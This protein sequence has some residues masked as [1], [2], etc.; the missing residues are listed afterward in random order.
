MLFTAVSNGQTCSPNSN[1]DENYKWATHSKWYYG[2]SNLLDFGASGTGAGTRVD[3]TGPVGWYQ[4]YESVASA[5]DNSG[6]LV[7]ATNGVELW[8]GTG[9]AIAVPGGRLLTGA[10][11]PTGDAGSAVHGVMIV[12]HPLDV[13]NYYIFTGDDAISGQTSAT[14]AVAATYGFNYYI[15]NAVSNSIT[16]GPIRLGNF[17]STEQIAAT[18]HANKVDVWI[19]T[20][21]SLALGASK[22]AS[23]NT[24]NAYLLKCS[25]LVTAPVPS[26]LGFEVTVGADWQGYPDRSNERASLKFSWDGTKAAATHHRGNGDVSA[27]TDCIGTMDFDNATGLFSAWNGINVNDVPHS[28]PYCCE[29]SPS[30]NRLFVSFQSDPWSVPTSDGRVEYFPVAGGAPTLVGSLNSTTDVG[31]LKLGGDGAIYGANFQLSPWARRDALIKISNP[32]G[33]ATWAET[34]VAS[35]AAAVS[36]GLPS[37]FIPPRDWLKI[38]V[39][40]AL[41]ECDLPYNFSTNWVCRATDAEN[42]LLY[43]PA[44]AVLSGPAGGS[45]NAITGVFDATAPGTYEITFTICT[46]ADTLEFVVGTCGCTAEVKPGPLEFCAGESVMLDSLLVSSSGPGTW[47]IDS[48][49]ASIPGTNLATIDHGLTD[50]MFVTTISTRPGTYKLM[51]TVTGGGCE[52]S[53]YI[54]VNPIPV[55][56][57]GSIGPFCKSDAAVVM[58]GSPQNGADTTGTWLIDGAASVSAS[59][60]PS[61]LAVGNHTVRYTATVDNC[62]DFIDSVFVINALPVAIVNHDTICT[63]V[64]MGTFTATADSAIASYLWSNNASG[65]I[66]TATG[67][68]AGNYTVQITDSHGC[69]DDTTG[70]LIVN[71]LPAIT[72]NDSTVCAGTSAKFTAVSDS[73][74]TGP[75]SGY[76][77]S[78]KG[79]GT[80]STTDGTIAGDYIV[81]VTDLHGCIGTATGVLTVNPLKDATITT[82]T[83]NDT[84]V[85]CALD[86]VD[87]TVSVAEGGGTWDNVNV[88][89]VGTVATIDLSSIAPATDLRLIYTLASPCGDADTIWI[90]TTSK[91]VASVAAMGPYC[92]SDN[93]NYLLTKSVTANDGGTWWVN[94]VQNLTDSINPSVLTD[95]SYAI[96]YRIGGLCG[97]TGTTTIVVDA[98][99]V[100]TIT[101]DASLCITANP[102][103]LTVDST[104]GTWT[105]ILPISGG[106]TSA[107]LTFNP[108]T[109]A[110]GDFEIAH[111]VTNGKCSHKD[112]VYITVIDTPKFVID[113]I[114][115]F[116]AGDAVKA[117]SISP[118][119]STGGTWS[120]TA[121]SGLV[122]STFDP[123][124]ASTSVTNTIRYTVGTCEVFQEIDVTVEEQSIAELPPNTGFC[125]ADPVYQ[126]VPVQSS[127]AGAATAYTATCGACFNA[128][129]QMFDPSLATIGSNTI[130]YTV[131]G[132]CDSTATMI[133]TVTQAAVITPTSPND[134]CVGDVTMP[135]TFSAAVGTATGTG[136][137]TLDAP[138]LGSIDPTTGVWSGASVTTGGTVSATYTFTT[139]DPPAPNGCVSFETTTMEVIDNPVIDFSRANEDSCV[140]YA[141]VFTDNTSYPQ[142]TLLGSTWDF[143]NGATGTN[144]GSDGTNYTVAGDYTVTLSN[145]YA[146][147]CKATASMIVRVFPLPNADF[148]WSPNPASILDPRIQFVSTGDLTD[149]YLWGFTSQ[150]TPE[151][152]T[153]MSP[154]SVFEV[155]GDDTIPVTLLVTNNYVTNL[156]NVQGCTD[157]ITKNVIIQDIFQLYVPNAFTPGAKADG[158]NDTF[159]PVGRNWALDNFEFVVL[160]RW[161]N[162]IFKTTTIG[163][164]WDGTVNG[165]ASSGKLAQND[166]YVWKITVK[167]I[168]TGKV[169][170]K[171]GAVTLVR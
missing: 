153:S 34:G 82:S 139:D 35:G 57:I 120:V 167:N 52:D 39:P 115:P 49:P 102:I 86:P 146:N 145:A 166:V 50:T 76:V 20:H 24:Y 41:T 55:P 83:G 81:T 63:G 51:Y 90:T 158:L 64:G 61:L 60:D 4:S 128:A 126:V 12:K 22:P 92:E 8:D 37:M 130:T 129:T 9:A 134:R 164:G 111:E 127:P 56:S 169:H 2:K 68:T 165:S 32:D 89:L 103:I 31:F 138:A 7:L 160:D 114:G 125:S 143:G 27:V 84:L 142:S 19:V 75:G 140:A 45:I 33:G 168:Y 155:D 112:T 38:V 135:S 44:Y 152:S 17:R 15:Y 73:A 118:S 25:G 21:E 72:V 116:C 10:E 141:D 100:A 106:F 98:Q 107:T 65:V 148:A 108:A 99:P 6:N 66:S 88:T 137:W 95:G 170:K 123:G 132:D 121:G 13:D 110:A 162:L 159:F 104:G 171:V 26:S 47:D 79:T 144:L 93:T 101:G 30:A 94:G 16:A 161:G 18:W 131:G 42:T 147:T 78:D 109:S 91:L 105:E 1:P 14:K 36:Y 53:I 157:T 71:V 58:T 96:E 122:G 28:N 149:E 113:P 85:L 124:A 46:I 154:A 117:L 77:W 69:I 67:T 59:F 11:I 54:T 97:D 87:P 23:N 151:T 156:G 119:D 163:V 43:E 150:G 3:L 74:V 80:V 70:I 48:V 29:F 133:I 40:P 62:T 5:C 136:V